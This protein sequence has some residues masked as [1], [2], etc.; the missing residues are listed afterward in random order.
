MNKVYF[1][2]THCAKTHNEFYIR[3]DLA[4]DDVWVRTYGLKS[5]PADE[6]SAAIG[7]KS[8]IDLTNER[9]GPQYKC[10]WCGNKHYWLHARCKSVICWDGTKNATCP[11]C[12]ISCTIGG[13]LTSISGSG[14]SGQ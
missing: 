6:M 4:A 2:K 9:C 10:P 14:S 5:L 7:S 13:T 1:I 11:V 8:E 12:N 3:Y